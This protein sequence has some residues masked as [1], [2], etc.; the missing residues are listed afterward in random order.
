LHE[1]EAGGEDAAGLDCGLQAA[2]SQG[3]ETVEDEGAAEDLA[4]V[5]VVT[6][7]ETAG[8]EDGGAW[9]GEGGAGGV[10][11]FPGLQSKPMWW[12]PISHS[13][14]LPL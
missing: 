14:L 10:Y 3:A 6:G 12:R 1:L 9:G 13:D 11:G 7:L 2:P 8:F 4:G 5:E